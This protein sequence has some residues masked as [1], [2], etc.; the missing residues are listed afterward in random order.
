M[1]EPHQISS[2]IMGPDELTNG[3]LPHGCVV[4]TPVRLAEVW[5]CAR[6]LA[7]VTL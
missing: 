3:M 6:K 2:G 7:L 5:G 4:P 1:L